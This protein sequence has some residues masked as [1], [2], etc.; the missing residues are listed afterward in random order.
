M[1]VLDTQCLTILQ[2]AASAEIGLCIKTNDPYKARASLYRFRKDLGDHELKQLQ[3]RV[4]PNDSEG[5]LWI[6]RNVNA[7][8]SITDLA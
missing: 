6:I 1:N 3:I 4:S 8:L 5:E 2:A 7:A